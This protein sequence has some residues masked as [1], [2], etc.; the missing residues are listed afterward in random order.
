MGAEPDYEPNA[1]HGA[2][3]AGGNPP[4]EDF[5]ED[6]QDT[7]GNSRPTG[8]KQRRRRRRTIVMLVVLVFFGGVVFGLTMF[9]RDLLGLNEIKDYEGAGTGSVSFTVAE[10]DG[11]MIIGTKLETADIVATAKE[12]VNAFAEEAEG[13]QIQPG[14]Y[15]MKQ[16]MSSSAALEALLGEQ[17][18]AVHYAAVA[19]DLRQGEVFDILSASTG[20]PLAEFEALAED[21]EAFGLPAEAVSLEGYL[22]PGEYRFPLEQDA[23]SIIEEMIGNTFAT[24]ED[25]EITDPAEQY[26]ILTKASIIQAEAGEADYAKV[27]GSIQNRLRA[28]NVE[29]SGLI[30]SDATVTYGLNRKSYDLTPEEKADKSNPYNTYANPGLP[31]GPIGSPSKE[32]IDAAA[33]PAD[34]PYYYWVTVNLDTGQTEFSSTLAEHAK[35]VLEYQEWC[36]TQKPGRCG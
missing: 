12:F 36:G 10:G 26:R 14:S 30:Q 34:V 28:D 16:Q 5:F 3:Q 8:E 7:R 31:V 25:A 13:R 29:T 24:L 32:A 1:H 27:A 15:E 4:V 23:T 35:Y 19:R 22:H 18:A 17:G 33:N 9:L 21:P 20:I 2:D 11:P 6:E